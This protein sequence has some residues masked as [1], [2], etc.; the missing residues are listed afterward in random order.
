[1]NDRITLKCVSDSDYEL[2]NDFVYSNSDSDYTH[3]FEWQ[4]IFEGS[5]SLK[6]LYL[7]VF[8]ENKLIGV[9]PSVFIK[10]PFKRKTLCSLPYLNFAG[11]ITNN[12]AD[13]SEIIKNIVNFLRTDNVSKI[14]LRNFYPQGDSTTGNCTLLLQLP[15]D[16]NILWDD[17]KPK[18]R[19]QIRKAYKH[20]FNISWGKENLDQ[21]YD[22][23]KHNMH[24]LGTPV[25][26][27]KF[28]KSIV[29]KFPDHT[30]ILTLFKDNTAVSSMFIFKF[31]NRIADP[32]A[33]SLKEFNEHCPNMLMYWE[34]FKYGIQNG[35]SEFDLGRSQFGSG[36]YN[37]KM[38]WGAKP[39][40]L[41]YE[42]LNI[43]TGEYEKSDQ[44]YRQKKAV[45]IAN[46]WKKL[47]RYLTDIVGPKLRP[48]LP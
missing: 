48:Y 39:V 44:F 35:F 22:V 11:L 7:G 20:G 4:K 42:T 38:Q 15:K 34:A 32:W 19:N 10:Y 41:R 33:S 1:M 14:E 9:L 37:F 18:V 29:E 27:I 43:V 21:F 47:P 45:F 40:N 31:K 28:F 30:D 16:E 5:Y 2:W 25:H 13:K 3:L 23:Y 17:L 8:Y 24:D 6:T 36:T 12:Y 46:L 26:S